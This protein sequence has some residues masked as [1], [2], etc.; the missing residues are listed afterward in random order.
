MCGDNLSWKFRTDYSLVIYGTGEMY[1]YKL[2]N[3]S[4]YAYKTTAPW[5]AVEDYVQSIEIGNKVESIGD[6]AFYHF[7]K[8]TKVELGDRIKTIGKSAFMYGGK[9]KII[10]IPDEVLSIGYQ[11]F[12]G[13]VNLETVNYNA[14]NCTYVGFSIS[15]QKYYS[16]FDNCWSLKT[17]NIGKNVKSIPNYIFCGV[18]GVTS[19]TIP[20]NVTSIGSYAFHRTGLKSVVIP[21]SVT[22]LDGSVFKDSTSLETAVIGNG[23]LSLN[24]SVFEG[25]T[26]LKSVTLP[27]NLRTIGG[28][29]FKNCAKLTCVNIPASVN[30]IYDS[31]FSD[32]MSLTSITIPEN[33]TYIGESAFYNC[34]GLTTVNYNAANCKT[35]GSSAKVVFENCSNLRTINIGKTVKSIPDYA[36]AWYLPVDSIAIPDS[37]TN[38]GSYAFAFCENFKNA[39]IPDSVTTIGAYAF[40]Y[41]YGMEY[42]HIPSSVTAI[43]ENVLKNTEAYICSDTLDCYAKTYSAENGIAFMLCDSHEG[44]HF[45]SY[46]AS[47]TA[48][49]TC[50]TPG[51]TVNTCSCGDRYQEG[52]PALGHKAGEW[53]TV[54]EATEETEGKKIKACTTC[55]ET[56]DEKILPVILIKTAV[57]NKFGIAL[58]YN[59]NSFN[60]AVA[61]LV[62]KTENQAVTSLV[63]EVAGSSEMQVHSI[64]MT[65]DGVVTQ[66][67]EAVTLRIP[68]PE[69]FDAEK[70]SVYSINPETGKVEEIAAE[71]ENGYFVFEATEMN[72]YAVVEKSSGGTGDDNGNEGDDNGNTGDNPGGNEDGEDIKIEAPIKNP[73]TTTISYGDSIVLHIDPSKIPEGG[74]VEWYPSNGNF[75]Y[76]VSSDGTTCTIT[77]NKKGD[78]TFTATVYDAEGNIISAD[79]QVM[80]SKAGFFDKIIAF[81][82]KLFGLTKTIPQIYKGIY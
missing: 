63:E 39:I 1:D 70:S 47:Q 24:G 68:L 19:I 14:T 53:Q 43:G 2:N 79:E 44:S 71:Y 5:N 7:D 82:K 38:I 29:S 42:I 12:Y 81:F 15:S 32:C 62:S 37:V 20:E 21:D 41:C 64:A 55:G 80:T 26:A 34:I 30:Y 74:Y 13:C 49:A 31:A 10:T 58:E 16:V 11:A 35:M 54:T 18:S 23:V 3:N 28:S 36:F 45:H 6:Y 4:L 46:T 69:N 57:D 65:V 27:Q 9:I 59:A 72:Y 48:V 52:V 73:T 40:G 78:T 67:E 76:S 51:V 75:G 77:P 33:A 22:T 61:I 60:G 8:L 66:P 50:T 17:I 56:V 25:C